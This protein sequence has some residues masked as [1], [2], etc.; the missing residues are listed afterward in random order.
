[1]SEPSGFSPGERHPSLSFLDAY[2]SDGQLVRL[3][4]GGEPPCEIVLDPKQDQLRLVLPSAGTEPDLARFRNLDLSTFTDDGAV[5]WEIRVAVNEHLH[6]GYYLLTRVADL[7]QL[8]GLPISIAVDD[9]L[10][11]YKSLLSARGLMSV[12][13]L[14]GLYGELLL[15]EHLLG[16]LDPHEV[17]Q[18]WYGP[19]SEEHDFV[20]GHAHFEVKTTTSEHRRHMISGTQ[21]LQRLRGVPLWLVSIQVTPSAPDGGRTLGKVIS[22]V[23]KL[24]GPARTA[25]DERL[26]YVGWRDA[27]A[28][29]YREHYA[30]RSQPRA[31]LVTDAF[32]HLTDQR[33]EL[34]TQ[35]A[36]LISDIRYRVD[37]TH[38]EHGL[39]PSP[40]DG[41][42]QAPKGDVDA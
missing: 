34:A 36:E 2:W 41:F 10:E 4:L 6:E 31:Y 11:A 12:E 20:F 17:V 23:R 5:W 21:Q 15:L 28:E 38:V 27:D 18:A 40:V 32:P 35:Y 9:A 25:F 24:A 42:V 3:P 37:V 29:L 7:V 39:P 16:E 22:D 30:L 1:M 14:V 8:D 13:V 33:L 26:S 19:L